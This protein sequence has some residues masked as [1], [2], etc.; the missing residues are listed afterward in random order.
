MSKHHDFPAYFLSTNTNT[1]TKPSVV[2]CVV[3]NE[4]SDGFV[5]NWTSF[6]FSIEVVKS[7][8]YP[9]FVNYFEN[10]IAEARNKI[11]CGNDFENTYKNLFFSEW[12][13]DYIFFID[14]KLNHFD[15]N[16]LINAI[17][18]MQNFPGIDIMSHSNNSIDN[19]DLKFTIFRKKIFENIAYPWF[20]ENKNI[21]KLFIQKLIDMKLNVEIDKSITIY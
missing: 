18:K 14:P 1:N 15:P 17:I 11:L 19:L 4:F 6:L 2:F 8:I 13:Y 12:N 20:E 10:N 5:N 16:N 3:G 7:K 21:D 9:H